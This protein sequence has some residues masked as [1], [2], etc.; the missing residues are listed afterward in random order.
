MTNIKQQ[1]LQS[2]DWCAEI[3]DITFPKLS[4]AHL[5]PERKKERKERKSEILDSFFFSQ[6]CEATED[7]ENINYIM[8][9]VKLHC[10]FSN[11][12]LENWKLISA[13]K[14]QIFIM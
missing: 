9:S 10:F 3:C 2:S 11:N 7:S 1:S 5:K 14:G 4:P 13:E 12:M 8:K 6:N